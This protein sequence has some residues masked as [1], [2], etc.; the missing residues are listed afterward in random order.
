MVDS[1]EN[2]V[3]QSQTLGVAKIGQSSLRDHAQPMILREGVQRLR[4][5]DRWERMA[6]E[7]SVAG[8]SED[9]AGHDSSVPEA[10]TDH[11]KQ[12]MHGSLVEVVEHLRHPDKIKAG[13]S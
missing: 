2:V 10:A 12:L 8:G 1:E 6:Q 5:M 11:L 9:V 7:A 13:G 4:R 3:A